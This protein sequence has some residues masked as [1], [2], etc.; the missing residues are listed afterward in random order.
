M[1]FF[2][3][4]TE[5]QEVKEVG[6]NFVHV[7]KIDGEPDS[8]C[9]DTEVK[10]SEARDICRP[11]AAL[12]S[13][14][15]FLIDNIN[16]LDRVH[17][18]TIANY[19]YILYNGMEPVD[20][21]LLRIQG[22]SSGLGYTY[23]QM[24]H[25]ALKDA[26]LFPLLLAPLPE[27]HHLCREH[28]IILRE[29]LHTRGKL[30]QHLLVPVQLMLHLSDAIERCA[31]TGGRPLLKD[32]LLF[33]QRCLQCCIVLCDFLEAHAEAVILGGHCCTAHMQAREFPG[34]IG[35]MWQLHLNV[36]DH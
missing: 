2:S 23:L 29:H 36:C 7:V 5:I 30:V 19:V 20:E 25:T 22:D 15:Y 28:H 21:F 33:V 18:Y 24:T 9:K 31:F 11:V 26:A 35:G 1:P 16:T 4:M 14:L 6:Y 12:G 3:R 32:L 34:V 13:L 8:H 10:T 27:L 17:H